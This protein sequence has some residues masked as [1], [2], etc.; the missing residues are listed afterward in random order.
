[1]QLK[2]WDVVVRPDRAAVRG[3]RK[4]QAE[5]VVK[6]GLASRCR[7]SLVDVI[8]A[9]VRAVSEATHRAGLMLLDIIMTCQDDGQRKPEFTQTFFL[10]RYRG[11]GQL[12]CSAA[13]GMVTNFKNSIVHAFEA[14][15]KLYVRTWLR[16]HNLRDKPFHVI[17]AIN[18][19]GV[20]E[21]LSPFAK[22]LVTSGASSAWSA[23]LPSTLPS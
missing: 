22:G 11:D 3:K 4:T 10:Q 5:R 17:K 13:A 20:R 12:Y 7:E 15:Q 23:T 9:R 14:R 2:E 8:R 1:M 16:S 19:W 21:A 6:V 18:S